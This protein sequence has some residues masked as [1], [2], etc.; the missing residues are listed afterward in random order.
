MFQAKLYESRE[1]LE[2]LLN[3]NVWDYVKPEFEKI[4]K[5]V[6]ILINKSKHMRRYKYTSE[7]NLEPIEDALEG[8][9]QSLVSYEEVAKSVNLDGA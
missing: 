9:Q 4:M 2:L 3:L 6:N 7:Q 1:E 5:E 8:L